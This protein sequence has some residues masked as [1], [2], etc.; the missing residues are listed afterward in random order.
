MTRPALVALMLVLNLSAM[1]AVAD[2]PKVGVSEWYPAKVGTEWHYRSSKGPMI[3][4]ITKHEKVGETMCAHIET[5][6]NDRVVANEDIAIGKSTVERHA[7]SGFRPEPP[8]VLAKFPLKEGDEWLIDSKIGGEEMKGK[9]VVEKESITV[10]AGKFETFKVRM[11]VESNGMTIRSESWYAKGVG[12]VK[13]Y[14]DLA[15]TELT[16]EL[17]KVVL[18]PSK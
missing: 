16:I 3:N 10:K 6:L 13:Q 4:K 18:P 1:D 9:A 8:V 2:E 17:E 5:R 7:F 12:M 14:M 15:G 11:E